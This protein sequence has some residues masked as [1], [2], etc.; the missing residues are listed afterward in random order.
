MSRYGEDDRDAYDET[1]QA[2]ATC[3]DCGIDYSKAEDDPSGCCDPCS[4]TRSRW[5]DAFE[6]RQMAKAV[7]RTDPLTIKDVA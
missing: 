3:A 6:V 1:L 2:N 4:D 5:A 7:L